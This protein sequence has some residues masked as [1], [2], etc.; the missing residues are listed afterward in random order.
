MR[1]GEVYCSQLFDFCDLD[2]HEDRP[3]APAAEDRMADFYKIPEEDRSWGLLLN[4]WRPGGGAEPRKRGPPPTVRKP[5]SRPKPVPVGQVPQAPAEPET[6]EDEGASPLKARL[7]RPRGEAS[8]GTGADSSE[9]QAAE[10]VPPESETPTDGA[11]EAQKEARRRKVS[12]VSF[13]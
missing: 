12:A 13:S 1:W 11:P 4:P 8:P 3:I 6:V 5:A 9:A 10:V 7:R 2:T